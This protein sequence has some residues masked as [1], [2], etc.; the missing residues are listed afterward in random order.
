M[1][2]D[3]QFA[4]MLGGFFGAFIGIFGG[5]VIGCMS[6]Y[7]IRKGYRKLFFGYIVFILLICA[8]LFIIGLVALLTKQPYHVWYVFIL[9]GGLGCLIMA[10]LTPTLK[11]RFTEA[12][13][14]QIKA[15][16]L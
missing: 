1:W 14:R 4:G 12:E 11:K 8:V 15:K 13:L 6:G 10:S 3:Q 7:C 9:P 16:D 5:G 2:F